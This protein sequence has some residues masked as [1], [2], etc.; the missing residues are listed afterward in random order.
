MEELTES[1]GYERPKKGWQGWREREVA[2]GKVGLRDR[3]REGQGQ[4]RYK[5]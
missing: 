4:V 3:L 1:M 2:G 5:P